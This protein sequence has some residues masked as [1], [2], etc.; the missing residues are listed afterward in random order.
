MSEKLAVKELLEQPDFISKVMTIMNAGM[1][2][3]LDYEGVRY[4]VDGVNVKIG[5][6]IIFVK[7]DIIEAWKEIDFYSHKIAEA[8][9]V[10][11]DNKEYYEDIEIEKDR[12]MII[13]IDVPF[14]KTPT[15]I[16]NPN[17]AKSKGLISGQPD[18]ENILNYEEYP[19]QGI[20][21][22]TTGKYKQG[23]RIGFSFVF[24]RPE[25]FRLKNET[26]LLIE[27]DNVLVKYK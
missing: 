11:E 15:V 24:R 8:Y 12:I 25:Y 7:K 20:V 27:K 6:Q 5:G 14:S 10:Y 17:E 9:K 2:S 23:D 26:Y 4:N 3:V 21:C 1:S 22:N 13:P 18:P 19:F 16:I